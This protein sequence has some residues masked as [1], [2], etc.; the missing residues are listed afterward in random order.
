VKL[1]KHRTTTLLATSLLWAGGIGLSAQGQDSLVTYEERAYSFQCPADWQRD[2][3]GAD[4]LFNLPD[5]DGKV[6]RS[7]YFSILSEKIGEVESLV[8]FVDDHFELSSAIWKKYGDELL[9]ETQSADHL[10]DY[11]I[12][13]QVLTLNE[14]KQR[15]HQWFLKTDNTVYIFELTCPL[16]DADLYYDVARDVVQSFILTE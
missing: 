13:Y 7:V 1:E 3:R 8:V 15:K 5:R 12:I 16:T 9:L 10:G 14:S 6:D 11:P 4:P 2:R